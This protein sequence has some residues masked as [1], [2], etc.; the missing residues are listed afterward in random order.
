VAVL[1]GLLAVEAADVL[2]RLA[3]DLVARL[4]AVVA[5]PQLVA[6]RADE[7][8]G[9]QDLQGGAVGICSLRLLPLGAHAR[10][11]EDVQAGTRNRPLD[12]GSHARER[13]K[14]LPDLAF[15]VEGLIHVEHDVARLDHP[16]DPDACARA[17]A[18]A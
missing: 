7:P 9:G 14:P 10:P 15:L 12:V 17:W 2:Q 13:F 3:D 5:A 16:T 4:D 1:G 8:A 6:G 11:E 18:T